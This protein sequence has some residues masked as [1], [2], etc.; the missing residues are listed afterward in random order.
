MDAD[1]FSELAIITGKSVTKMLVL[2]KC[3]LDEEKLSAFCQKCK[4]EKLQVGQTLY[5][6]QPCNPNLL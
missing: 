4:D 5:R 1:G 3:K 2:A 6:H